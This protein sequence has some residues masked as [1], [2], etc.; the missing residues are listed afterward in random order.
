MATHSSVL[1][2]KPTDRGA[3]WVAALGVAKSWTQLG[4]CFLTKRHQKVG[5][6]L[7]FRDVLEPS[8]R[9]PQAQPGPCPLPIPSKAP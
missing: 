2:W 8:N 4:N 9:G 3:W 5:H 7:T 6:L 1:A